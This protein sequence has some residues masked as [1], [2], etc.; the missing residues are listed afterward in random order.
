MILKFSRSTP[1][2]SLAT[3]SIPSYL[4]ITKTSK[5]W[6]IFGKLF[7]TFETQITMDENST[8]KS[9]FLDLQRAAN[10]LEDAAYL[11]QSIADSLN[12]ETVLL[13]NGNRTTPMSGPGG[14]PSV[15]Y[16][17]YHGEGVPPAETKEDTKAAL[18]LNN[19]HK[20]TSAVIGLCMSFD[21]TE[22]PFALSYERG[23]QDLGT[24]YTGR[25]PGNPEHDESDGTG[26]DEDSDTG[27]DDSRT[28]IRHFIQKFGSSEAE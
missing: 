7:I 25:Q 27:S 28:I 12:E 16:E 10:N 21:G 1:S 4:Y 8:K 15:S 22:E 14:Y 17:K 20:G 23:F 18:I 19:M 6:R 5:P 26:S 11:I 13:I 2:F 3:S 9:T 24:N